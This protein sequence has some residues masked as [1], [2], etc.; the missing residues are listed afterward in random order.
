MRYRHPRR[1]ELYKRHSEGHWLMQFTAP[2]GRRVHR[3]TQT[4]DPKEAEEC[5]D[6][7]RGRL[8]RVS[9][10]GERPPR[11]FDEAADRYLQ[12]Q[13]RAGRRSLHKMRRHRR[14]LGHWL[15]ALELEAIGPEIIEAL[16]ER[17]IAEGVAPA[18]VNRL[19]AQLRGTLRAAHRWG[20][21]SAAPAIT[22]LPESEGRVRYLTPDEAARLLGELPPHLR[23]MARFTLATG[24]R[25]SNVRGLEWHEVDL[26]RRLAVIPAAKAKNKRALSVPLNAEAVLV[27]RAQL[28]RHPRF[29][30]TYRGRPLRRCL[31][32]RG[33]RHALERA[34]IADFRW[35]DLRHTW[36]SWHVMGGTPLHVLMQLGGWSSY[37][38]VLRYA[39]LSPE[40]L[41]E[42]ADRLAR[43]RLVK[44]GAAHDLHTRPPK[45]IT[46]ER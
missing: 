32:G 13:A 6:H 5:L 26:E 42:A 40:H 1:K 10:L 25:E 19:L 28:G 8:W 11:T 38:M 17:R 39:H 24:L 46:R 33:W 35:H 27:I 44:G 21:L 34:G 31:S 15:D 2:D 37:P 9:K 43:P 22:L 16:T 7:C 3:S 4:R 45:G 14:W 30:F 29:V 23:A 20:W 12:E 18:T 41:A 36:A